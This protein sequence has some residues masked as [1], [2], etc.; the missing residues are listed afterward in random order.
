MMKE[1]YEELF[2]IYLKEIQRVQDIAVKLPE[3]VPDIREL[4]EGNYF[5]YYDTDIW[6]VDTISKFTKTIAEMH[7]TSSFISMV[8]IDLIELSEEEKQVMSNVLARA[9]HKFN[10]NQ[11]YAGIE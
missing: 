3:T 5:L 11:N 10:T 1:Y 7:P 6:D 2:K 8:G 4:K 9:K